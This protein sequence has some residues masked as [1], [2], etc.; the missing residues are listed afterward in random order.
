MV[1][2]DNIQAMWLIDENVMIFRSLTWLNPIIV[3]TIRQEIIIIVMKSKLILLFIRSIIGAIFC[4]VRRIRQ[5]IQFNPSITSG[6]QKWN[7]AAPSLINNAE[8][9]I[10]IKLEFIRGVINSF[11]NNNMITDINRII[12]ATAWVIKYF[13]DDSDEKIFFCLL[14]RGIID[15][16]LISRPIHILNHE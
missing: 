10:I 3:L 13:N 6:N 11:V 5:F 1:M 8:F 2:A 15:S 4:H 9:I 7:G 14:N 12:D 16:K